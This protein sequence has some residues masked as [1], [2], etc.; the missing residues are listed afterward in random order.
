M[1]FIWRLYIPRTNRF[2]L[3][4]I[5]SSHWPLEG[6]LMGMGGAKRGARQSRLTKR[7]T[8]GRIGCSAKRFLDTNFAISRPWQTT[9]SVS[10]GSLRPTSAR[11]C[12]WV[13]RCRITNVPA[14]PMLTVPR[15]FS[16]SAS[17]VGRNFRCPPTLTPL[18]KTTSATCFS[19]P[20]SDIAQDL[21]LKRGTRRVFGDFSTR[22]AASTR[23]RLFL[24]ATTRSVRS[25]GLLTA[26]AETGKRRVAKYR[27]LRMEL[28][29]RMEISL[30]GGS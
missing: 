9:I 6:N 12:A 15:C 1:T 11:T 8:S 16:C 23:C 28:L 17:L 25:A 19:V 13:T 24:R 10:N 4:I 14:A 27:L 7:T 29:I 22:N 26:A 21:T 18:R 3:A 5:F 2:R 20:I 30:S